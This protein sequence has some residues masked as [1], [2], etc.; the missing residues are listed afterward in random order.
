MCLFLK[1]YFLFILFII[2]KIGIG[3]RNGTQI[4]RKHRPR[5]WNLSK[6]LG[7]MGNGIF[8]PLP[9][10][11]SSPF[12]QTIEKR[13]QTKREFNNQSGFPTSVSHCCGMDTWELTCNSPQHF[14]VRINSGVCILHVGVACFSLTRKV[15]ER[16]KIASASHYKST[17]I[18]CVKAFSLYRKKQQ[19]LSN[20]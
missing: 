12:L 14:N 3:G 18:Y 2:G 16:T 7:C 13:Q 10:P 17:N 8:T 6:N 15:A 9:A 1:F 4:R 11:N 5:K 19:K 20:I